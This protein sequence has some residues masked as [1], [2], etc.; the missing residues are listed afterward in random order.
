MARKK[1]TDESLAQLH[2]L[3][4]QLH[5]ASLDGLR[6]AYAFG[7][8]VDALASIGYTYETMGHEV[9]R[10]ASTVYQYARLYGRYNSVQELLDTAERWGTYDI[11]RLVGS[12]AQ[13][14]RRYGY[15][16]NTCFSWN[17]SRKTMPESE[18][19]G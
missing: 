18:L 11:S 13:L 19:V 9:N 2:D 5:H 17:T 7:Q 10:S 3:F 8:M 6:K 4:D 12:D 16:C 1:I 14:H 15:Q